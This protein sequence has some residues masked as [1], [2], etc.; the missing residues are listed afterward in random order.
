MYRKYADPRN[1]FNLYIVDG[2]FGELVEKIINDENKRLIAEAEKENDRRYWELFLHS[3]TEKSYAQWKKDII[4]S[5]RTNTGKR[6]ADMTE[7]DVDTLLKKLFPS[8]A[9]Q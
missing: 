6:D 1:I 9:K 2:R 5:Q 7:K 3:N 4:S 8:R